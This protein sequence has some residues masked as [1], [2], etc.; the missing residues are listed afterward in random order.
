MPFQSITIPLSQTNQFSKLFLDFVNNEDKIQNLISYKPNIQGFAEIIKQKKYKTE[1]R[2]ILVDAIEKNYQ[3]NEIS[4]SEKV[5]KN[6]EILKSE[7]TFTVTTGHQLCLMTGPLYFIFKIITTINL[8]KK[9]KAEFPEKNFVP[10]YWMASE[11]HDFE[12][13][14][15][16]SLFGKTH[17]WQSNQKGA[18]GEFDIADLA[19]FLTSVSAENP[20]I[21]HYKNKKNLAAATA[22]LV[23]QLFENEGLIILDGNQ[24]S[25]KSLFISQIKKDVF[26][27]IAFETITEQS[28][29]IVDLGYTAQIHPR[30]I[31]FFYLQSNSRERIVKE[32]NRFT[33]LNTSLSFSEKEMEDEIENFPERFSPN[34]CLRPL[35]QEVILPN[36][37]YIG[38]PGEIA[39]WLQLKTFFETSREVFPLLIP[40]NFALIVPK[41]TEDK[42][43]KLKISVADLF[44]DSQSLKKLYLK[45]NGQKNLDFENYKTKIAEVFEALKKEISEIDG[46]LAGFV[47]AQ[48]N[49]SAKQ[50]DLISKKATKALETKENTQIEQ[51]LNIQAKLFP[52]GSLQERKVNFLN[53]ELNNPNFIVN[54]ID[55]FD[56]LDFQFNIFIDEK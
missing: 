22:S 41:N 32:N 31:N 16:F 56:P 2:A 27:N 54:L 5:R 40:R 34:V 49:E 9:L 52:D 18:V 33:I 44:L 23:N 12:E 26:E 47:D 13:V 25:L 38:G 35:Y 7:N 14:N 20:Y 51:L 19:N 17:S 30:E 43:T 50:F 39:Y 3:N 11:D 1:N 8:A 45:S 4:I 10:V 28:K 24:K 42:L 53:F 6:I 37:A 15:H 29:K 21:S 55:K 48:K 36:V 46:S